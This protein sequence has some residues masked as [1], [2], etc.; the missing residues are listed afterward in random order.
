MVVFQEGEASAM[1]E[2]TK[3]VVDAANR[4]RWRSSPAGPA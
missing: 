1:F 2:I 3:K 4:S